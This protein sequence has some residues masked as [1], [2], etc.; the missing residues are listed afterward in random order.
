[1]FGIDNYIV[2]LVRYI[3]SMSLN[4]AID[5]QSIFGSCCRMTCPSFSF[6]DFCRGCLVRYLVHAVDSLF[7]FV[8]CM[9]RLL[10]TLLTVYVDDTNEGTAVVHCT[11]VDGS[12]HIY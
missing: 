7:W 2:Y 11:W 1:M 3:V 9:Y 10:R 8:M 12:S 6:I 5:F 4:C